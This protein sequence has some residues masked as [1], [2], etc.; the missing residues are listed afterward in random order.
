VSILISTG[1]WVGLLRG[2]Q[3]A[4]NSS[5]MSIGEPQH[6]QGWT[7]LSVASASVGA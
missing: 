5:M 4:S 1:I 2:V 6:G 3:P 7:G